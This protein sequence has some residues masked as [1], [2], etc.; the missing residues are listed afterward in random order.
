MAGGAA[1][2]GGAAATAAAAAVAAGCQPGPRVATLVTAAGPVGAAAERSPRHVGGGDAEHRSTDQARCRRR[3]DRGCQR[4]DLRRVLPDGNENLN[5]DQHGRWQH[6]D[7]HPALVDAKVLGEGGGGAGC[8]KVL[9]GALCS[10]SK[11]HARNRRRR[12][13]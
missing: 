4:D 10:E 11:G 7:A 5:E 13:R 8:S 9:D 1:V 2:A 12:R 6:G 3:R